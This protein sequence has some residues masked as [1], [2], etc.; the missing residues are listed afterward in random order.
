LQPLTASICGMRVA[1]IRE[2][3][4]RSV[5]GEGEHACARLD[6]RGKFP[7]AHVAPLRTGRQCKPL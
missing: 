3:G 7:N 6:S 2:A 4:K 1:A 5:I